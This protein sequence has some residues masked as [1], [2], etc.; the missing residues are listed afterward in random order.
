MFPQDCSLGY[1]AE[2]VS[3]KCKPTC[4][5]ASSPSSIVGASVADPLTRVCQSVCNGSLFADYVAGLCVSEC[6]TNN[7]YADVDSGYRCVLSC[8]LSGS[9]PWRDNNTWTCVADCNDT[10]VDNF[11]R[12]NTTWMC[13]F[14][15]PPNYYADYITTDNPIC[16]P[17]CLNGTY[18]D[19][20]TGTGLCVYRCS[21]YPPRFGDA[22]SGMNLCV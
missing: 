14:D 12:D 9:T 19:N 22:T 20:S 21:Q 10:G 16:R 13:V 8:N 5:T 3:Q 11:L 7:T 17:V 1:Y 15:C 4:P 6:H 18:A 2:N